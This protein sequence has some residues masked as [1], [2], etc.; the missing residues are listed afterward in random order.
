MR[1]KTVS[2]VAVWMVTA[3]AAATVWGQGMLVP[4]G[5]PAPTM[6]TLLQVEPRTP[7]DSIPYTVTES[8]SYYVTSNLVSTGDGITIQASYVTVDLMGFTLEGDSSGGSDYGVFLN[9]NTNELDFLHGVTVMNGIVRGFFDGLRVEQSQGCRF[10][11]L[12]LT[13]STRNGAIFYGNFSQCYGNVVE[14]C[15]LR[16]NGDYGIRLE[17][18]KGDCSGNRILQCNIDQNANGGV[19]FNASGG[20][21]RGNSVVGCT[22]V[23]NGSFGISAYAADGSRFERN[24]FSAQVGATTYGIRSYGGPQ[25]FIFGNTAWGNTNNFAPSGADT[26]GPIVTT[27]GELSASDPW[28]NFSR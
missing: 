28:A 8:G 17:S 27:S 5:S 1:R 2:E 19:F 23:G 21:C 16:D 9:G 22:M 15:S 12:V 20:V 18:Y 10:E 14:D 7:I 11:H 4:P 24:H 25:S 26:Y 13:G 6:R 3:V